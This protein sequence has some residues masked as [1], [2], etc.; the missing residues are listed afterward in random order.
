MVD[1][2]KRREKLGLSQQ[3]LGELCGIT[4]TAIRNIEM[5][6]SRPSIRT[7]KL[8]APILDCNWWDL[9]DD[10]DENVGVSEDN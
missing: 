8:L 7:A 1:V 6:K 2:R 10:N 5:G 4:R 3:R 9:F